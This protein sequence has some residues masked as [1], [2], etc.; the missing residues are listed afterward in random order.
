MQSQNKSKLIGRIAR[1][2]HA[3]KYE[4]EIVEVVARKEK[5]GIAKSI[6]RMNSQI[7]MP[8]GYGSSS[9]QISMPDTVYYYVSYRCRG[10]YYAAKYDKYYRNVWFQH[11][12]L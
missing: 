12:R 10:G 5:R 9:F 7:G 6:R 1:Y 3:K 4:I 2:N 8:D 11:E